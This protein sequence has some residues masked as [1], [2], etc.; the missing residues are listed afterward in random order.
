MR[1]YSTLILLLLFINITSAKGDKKEYQINT[2]NANFIHV[3]GHFDDQAWENI[4]WETGFIQRDP[5]EGA[6]PSEKTAFKL[7]Y[8]NEN[9]YVAIKALDSKPGKIVRRIARRDNIDGDRVLIQ[10]DSYADHLTAF[11]FMCN[12]A[13]VK[14]D[15]I[16]NNN[17][18]VENY[19]WNP[20]WEVKTKITE[21]GW[22]AEMRIPL[23]QLRFSDNSQEWGI[24]LGR[25]IHRYGELSYWQAVPQDAGGWVSE[26]GKLSGLNNIEPKKELALVPY[27]LA[28]TKRY[29]AQKSNPYASGTDYNFVAGLDGKIG[30]TNNLTLDLTINPDF[31]QVEADPSEVNLT[32]FESYFQEKRPFFIEG[33]NIMSYELNYGD[34]GGNENLFYSRRIGRTPQHSP[35]I[36]D[37]AYMDQP[38]NTSIISAMKLTGKTKQGWSVGILE[39]M[40]SAENAL[41]NYEGDERKEL[42]EPF[43]NYFLGRIKKDFDEGNTSLGAIFTATNR[44]INTKQLEFLH[45]EAYSGGIDFRHTWKDRTYYLDFKSYFSRVAGTQES[46]LRTQTS[47]ARYFQRPDANYL[48]VDSTLNSLSGM[49]GNLRIGKAGNGHFRYAGWV[50]WKSP[51][52]ELNDMGYLRNSDKIEN[53]LWVQYRIWEP[54]GIFRSMRYNFALFNSWNFGGKRLYSGISTNFHLQ[55]K[56]YWGFSMGFN[57]HTQ[58]YNQSVLR[59]GP[60]I[61]V[62]GNFGMWTNM[63]TDHRKDVQFFAGSF[64][65]WGNNNSYEIQNFWLR[66]HYRPS[67]A[68]QLSL[69]PSYNIRNSPYQY[70]TTKNFDDEDR[71]LLGTID[72]RTLSMEIRVNYSITPEL[73]IQY[74]GM[75]FISAGKYK[76]IQRVTNPMAGNL[77]D[78]FTKFSE[79]EMSYDEN[80]DIYSIDENAD[81]TIDYSIENPDY[82]FLQFRSNLVGRWEFKPG[83]ILYLVWSQGRTDSYSQGILNSQDMHTLFDTYP[84]NVFLVKLSYRLSPG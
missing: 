83:S 36:K 53:I 68:I 17:G 32:A 34:G 64:S 26:F 84:E 77:Q 51:G 48:S 20:V 70:I 1:I 42:V 27:T 28:Q 21:E 81:G 40:T 50:T 60:A 15:W 57:P 74:Y 16:I 19:D 79:N 35:D 13:G 75:P 37:G 66:I 59:G 73:T 52:L 14:T 10:F 43:T 62:P 5:Y 22:N 63:H 29:Q 71:Y 39:T 30:I 56:N 80:S 23:S 2:T 11:S 4:D 61:Y 69:S 46:I 25:Y 76:S 45:R 49:G 9:I 82:N 33:R 31:G 55:F 18:E 8:D 12:A 67:N 3:D 41:I 72:Q 65:Q 24:Q 7:L 47:S 58:I 44:N 38:Q 54:M 6:S 78:R